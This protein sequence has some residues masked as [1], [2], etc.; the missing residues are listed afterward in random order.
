MSKENFYILLSRY[1]SGQCSAREKRLVEQ[2][3]MLLDHDL[4][5]AATGDSTDLEE[6]LWKAIQAEKKSYSRG[7]H[8]APAWKWVAAAVLVVSI[9]LGFMY[10][11][12]W[13]GENV[14]GFGNIGQAAGQFTKVSTGGEEKLLVLPDGSEIRLSPYSR[15]EYPG[16]FEKRE[17]Y[18]E[19]KAFFKVT[20]DGNRP[21]LVYSG[22]IVTR[23]LGTSFWI[24]G[25]KSGSDVEVSVVTGK[26]SVTKRSEANDMQAG[27]VK[28]GAILTANQKVRYFN[29]SQLFET[30]LVD[31]PV[32][33]HPDDAQHMPVIRF[34]FDDTPIADVVSALEQAYG[35]EIILANDA[36]K[37]C[38]FRGD[39][40]QQPLY[41][42][43]DLLCASV[44]AEY[45]IRGTR[46]LVSGKGCSD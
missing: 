5:T 12:H 2:W 18:L 33:L 44:G 37:K 38:L 46:V 34:E 15:L 4:P 9:A 43:L 32:P 42:K 31:H 7:I 27:P 40:T 25:S 13:R 22:E 8:R 30:G 36:L 21:F 41:T 1:R 29:E 14:T 6:K 45:E 3:L 26:V 19:G 11:G 16:K 20:P 35:I 23:V 10:P 17:V 24:D 39:I 28:T